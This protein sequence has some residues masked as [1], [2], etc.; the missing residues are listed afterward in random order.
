MS[1]GNQQ[2]IIERQ[3]FELEYFSRE[4]VPML[5]DRLSKLFKEKII[6]SLE[7]LFDRMIDPAEH[8][9]MSSLEVDIGKLNENWD[10]EEFVERII[11][12][13]EEELSF[14]ITRALNDSGYRS[15]IQGQDPGNRSLR[16]LDHFLLNGSLP[17]WAAAAER[18][19][20]KKLLSGL[21]FSAKPELKA[22][23]LKSA[24]LPHVRSRLVYQFDEPSIHIALQLIEPD[25]SD[26]IIAFHK[27][28][29]KTQEEQQ[30][31]KNDTQSFEKAVWEFILEYL[32]LE[33]QS[34]FNK[35]SF[36]EA[37]LKRLAARYNISFAQV[38]SLFVSAIP[39]LSRKVTTDL[40]ELLLTLSVEYDSKAFPYGPGVAKEV[41][42]FATERI[43]ENQITDELVLELIGYYLVYGSIPAVLGWADAAY[44]KK[45]IQYL[46]NKQEQGLLHLFS[47]QLSAPLVLQRL[48]K[49]FTFDELYSL[50]KSIHAPLWLPP[51]GFFAELIKMAS[52]E[53]ELH[54]DHSLEIVLGTLLLNGLPGKNRH[55]VN[56]FSDYIKYLFLH[57]P[58]PR[59][60][61]TDLL[62]PYKSEVLNLHDLLKK[63]AS[64]GVNSLEKDR[65]END[66]EAFSS[67]WAEAKKIYRQ[68]LFRY[69][70]EHG[71]SPWWIGK[72]P[73]QDF[74]Q[75]FESITESDPGFVI[76]IIRYS[77]ANDTAKYHLL[78]LVSTESLLAGFS[79]LFPGSEQGKQAWLY[80]RKSLL[81]IHMAGSNDFLR[82]EKNLA[83]LF[84]E[85][86]K[87]SGYAGFNVR[88]FLKN[89][90]DYLAVFERVSLEKLIM[91]IRMSSGAMAQEFNGLVMDSRNKGRILSA[92]V[93]QQKSFYEV[94]GQSVQSHFAVHN[95]WLQYSLTHNAKQPDGQIL[96]IYAH[97]LESGHLPFDYGFTEKDS[98]LFRAAIR[99]YLKDPYFA[100]HRAK[101]LSAEQDLRL[102]EQLFLEKGVTP[103]TIRLKS[104]V[105]V[106]AELLK[107][108][109]SSTALVIPQGLLGN[110]AQLALRAIRH[111]MLGGSLPAHY[112]FSNERQ[113]LALLK[114]LINKGNEED[115][116][117][118]SEIFQTAAYQPQALMKLMQ[119]VYLPPADD[120]LSGMLENFVH[121]HFIRAFSD[122]GFIH[123]MWEN[124]QTHSVFSGINSKRM[125]AFVK[126]LANG[127]LRVYVAKNSSIEEITELIYKQNTSWDKFHLQEIRSGYQWM[128]NQMS[129]ALEKEHL[130]VLFKEF[131]LLQLVAKETFQDSAWFFG[132]FLKFVSSRRN[133]I[134]KQLLETTA[135]KETGGLR[136]QELP[137]GLEEKLTNMAGEYFANSKVREEFA[138]AELRLLKQFNK[139]ELFEQ[140]ELLGDYN[141]FE[142]DLELSGASFFIQ[143]A[144]LVILHP[145]LKTFFINL[146]L[147]KEGKFIS[148]T[149]R[150]KAIH[151]LEFLIDG[152]LEHSED[153]L[154]LN[155]ILCGWPVMAPVPLSVKLTK[156]QIQHCEDFISAVLSM[157]EQMKNSS[158][159][160]FR[161]AF[162]KRDG[163]LRN[164]QGD[165][166]LR[167][168]PTGYDVLLQT[169]PW[170]YGVIKNAFMET[171]IYVEWI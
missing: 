71:Y 113:E 64:E 92:S 3:V 6:F 126:L 36:A 145:Y 134:F 42:A 138:Q 95:S 35:L 91:T 16:L 98:M 10:E 30:I 165:W 156:A 122:W 120:I 153:T 139:Q 80:L 100:D 135:K 67:F 27:D 99:S 128:S 70:L 111:F 4:K 168:E 32:L 20:W 11:R 90:I 53:Y 58:V 114:Q 170:G 133:I 84:W 101:L 158:H 51:V 77:G 112:T 50:A 136:D 59:S 102:F 38:L 7:K 159:S 47:Q 124:E 5:Q 82:I 149:A 140:P 131:L 78:M 119:L 60:R 86:L 130:A 116:N 34:V 171:T 22:L 65:S 108:I 37:T 8:F 76:S 167:I 9:N 163:V 44:L 155:K 49:L 2:H 1:G 17:W 154:M 161:G 54:H 46:M 89:V 25:H 110:D 121:R 55:S 160:N 97:F 29:T 118:L 143:N 115:H 68:D 12:A 28:L 129:D 123:K 24:K 104:G 62:E 39:K 151:A 141:T 56:D 23:I 164:E 166:N 45:N 26:Y 75:F 14:K 93:L 150:F 31:V 103:D 107:S 162:L 132:N 94:I 74:D 41:K 109:L 21:F 106:G 105:S 52:L 85:A 88:N 83:G 96:K 43:S 48:L 146:G 79:K 69:S 125:G 13:V 61:I 19:D 147:V 127:Q 15:S 66:I 72:D 40:F 137:E 169:L 73:L 81:E 144:G 33:N 148:K 157:W 63:A 142:D 18:P 57:L 152:C 87:S 117:L